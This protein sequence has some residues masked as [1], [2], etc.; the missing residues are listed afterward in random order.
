M[1]GRMNHFRSPRRGESFRKGTGLGIAAPCVLALAGILSL[2]APAAA[3]RVEKAAAKPTPTSGTPAAE[4]EG[5]SDFG[6]GAAVAREGPP[7]MADL[8]NAEPQGWEMYFK[9][10]AV[11]SFGGGFFEK[12][13]ATG[14]TA[15]L[16]L[17]Q[18]LYRPAGPWMLFAEFGGGYTSNT[19]LRS[20]PVTTSGTVFFR[21]PDDDHIHPTEDFYRTRIN[22]LHRYFVQGAMG[23]FWYPP[24]FNSPGERLVH[25][26]ARAGMRVGG[27]RTSYDH[28]VA[29]GL[30]A[31]FLGHTSPP[32]AGHN[33][34]PNAALFFPGAAE[35]EVFFGVFGSVGVGMTYF[36]ARL[37]G[38]RFADITLS[39]EV[40]LGHEWFDM[41]AYGKRDPGFASVTPMLSLAFSF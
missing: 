34:N 31:I 41:G 28:E 5:V 30:R 32:P 22:E 10:G 2:A 3:Q 15:Q 23:A 13:I 6:S 17:R 40:E 21:Q 8:V 37:F 9:G 35:P 18:P 26:N 36:D 4:P 19:G 25:V 29:P 38:R 12:Q 11:F 16:G 20:D 33:H 1:L 7:V 24:G 27:M 39:A 14:W